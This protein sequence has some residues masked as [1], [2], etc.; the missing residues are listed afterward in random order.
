MSE[1]AEQVKMVMTENKR[2]SEKN[3]KLE[4]QNRRNNLIFHGL[5]EETTQSESWN[6]VE[7]KVKKLCCETLEFPNPPTIEKAH[8]IGRARRQQ[9]ETQSDIDRGRGGANAPPQRQQT[10]RADCRPVIVTFSSWKEKEDILRVARRSLKGTPFKVTEDFCD[11]TRNVRKKLISFID[12]KK[13]QFPGKK[14]TLKYD[15]LLI[16]GNLYEL[17]DDNSDVIP[18]N[19]NPRQ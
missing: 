12:I 4:D 13:E 5:N 9:S 2:L 14:V 19:V 3:K 17:K 6:K 1:L 8:R 18:V 15:K 11:D 7:D 10:T 16:D